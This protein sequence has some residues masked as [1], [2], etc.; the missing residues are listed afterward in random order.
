MD[1]ARILAKSVDELKDTDIAD[2]ALDRL[3]TS[4]IRD[5]YVLSRRGPAQAKFTNPEIRELGELEDAD[6]IVL[7]E[8]LRLDPSSEQ[9]IAQDPRAA[10]NLEIL[11]EFAE[12]TPSGKRKR[13]H[14]R[15]LVSPT[16]ILSNGSGSVASMRIERNELRSD[17][18]G[19]LNARGAGVFEKL[20]AGLVLRSVGYKGLPLDGVPYDQRSGTIPN[21]EGRVIDPATGQRLSG[22]YVVGWAKRGPSGVIGTNKPDA[23][24][25]V[26]HMLSD[27][28]STPGAPQPD[29]SAIDAILEQRELQSISIDAWRILDGI[30]IA[31]GQ[32]QGRPRVKFTHVK[33][34]L[35][36]LNQALRMPASD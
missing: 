27:I 5:I 21:R 11:R 10:R 18:S 26:A 33:D 36:A 1:V 3:A 2:H 12:R 13:L 32:K 25:T 9:E 17:E 7:P 15:F 4:H 35:D 14:L 19:Y 22:E 34:M 8:E 31:E 30:E 24:E 6:I 16:E 29:P 28:E 23:L 20:D